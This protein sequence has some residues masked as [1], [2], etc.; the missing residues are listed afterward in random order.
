M[1]THTQS[2]RCITHKELGRWCGGAHG[3]RGSGR[4]S[5]CLFEVSIRLLGSCSLL[6][7]FV[8]H[9]V[10]DESMCD[11]LHF[12]VHN[13]GVFSFS[14][15]VVHLFMLRRKNGAQIKKQREKRRGPVFR[16]KKYLSHE[17]G[18]GERGIQNLREVG[19][20]IIEMIV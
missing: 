17:P 9:Y 3:S 5:L 4:C 16:V 11:T 13:A 8:T 18:V 7:C 14:V 6:S 10:S 19:H 15:D 2:R 20:E 1:N 12:A